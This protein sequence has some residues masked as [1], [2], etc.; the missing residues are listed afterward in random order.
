MNTEKDNFFKEIYISAS[1]VDSYLEINE[2]TYKD[3]SGLEFDNKI[4]L[5]INSI[6]IHIS[7][8]DNIINIK[9]HDNIDI[10]YIVLTKKEKIENYNDLSCDKILYLWNHYRKT[11][12]IK[13][14]FHCSFLVIY[15]DFFNDYYDNHLKTSS[16]W[17]GFKHEQMQVSNYKPVLELVC[18]ENQIIFP[19]SFNEATSNSSSYSSNIY[20]IFLKKYHQLELVFNLIFVKQIQQIDINDLKQINSIYKN[21]NKDEIDAINYIVSNFSSENKKSKILKIIQLAFDQYSSICEELLFEYGK[22]SNPLKTDDLKT[23]FHSFIEKCNQESP[24]NFDAYKSICNTLKFKHKE[25]EFEGF[26][27]KLT[28]YF[29]YRIRCS[30]AHSKLS[31]FIFSLDQDHLNF[32]TDIALPLISET[33]IDVFSNNDFNNLFTQEES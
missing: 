7:N 3:F 6:E 1:G 10:G 31:E 4:I 18:P 5:D 12:E 29:I 15:K 14:S 8:D 32:M 22:E 11:S 17:G 24:A 13:N 19:T 20:D 33:V 25:G 23:K 9:N 28:C 2:Y 27:N 16:L 30:I 21:M 26:V